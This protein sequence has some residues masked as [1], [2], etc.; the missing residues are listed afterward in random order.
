MLPIPNSAAHRSGILILQL[1]TFAGVFTL[2]KRLGLTQGA[3][4]SGTLVALCALEVAAPIL[5]TFV[6]DGLR[7]GGYGAETSISRGADGHVSAKE[8]RDSTTKKLLEVDKADLARIPYAWPTIAL[9]LFSVGLY[10]ASLPLLV[11]GAI[12]SVTAF[13]LSSLATSAPSTPF[14]VGWKLLLLW[15]R[16]CAVCMPSLCD[17]ACVCECER[18]HHLQISRLHS[19]A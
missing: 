4:T 2:C 16:C 10:V 12:G 7:V 19:D 15:V 14:V 3:T 13:S 17:R 5:F 1:L 11:T 8:E 9:A 18:T 6:V